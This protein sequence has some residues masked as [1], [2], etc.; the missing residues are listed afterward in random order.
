MT[1]LA[2]LHRDD[3]LVR[4]ILA[5]FA[6]VE[7]VTRG[8]SSA[9][10][11]LLGGRR[12]VVRAVAIAAVVTAALAVMVATPAW[13]LVRDVLPFWSQPVAS[14]PDQRAFAELNVG[15][16]SGMSPDVVAGETREVAH[17]NYG[18]TAR[19][20]WVAPAKNGGFCELWQPGGGG[21]NTGTTLQPL[22][23]T[24]VAFPP[25]LQSSEYAGLE[26]LSGFA[27]MPT[28]SDVVIRFSDGSSIRPQII[29]VS[30][31]INAGFFAYDIPSTQQTDA[32]HVTEIDAYDA[33]GNLVKRD[34]IE[35]LG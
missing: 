27:M 19:T 32:D 30:A 12:R 17:G 4:E 21:C 8:R 31:P 29:W 24:A 6:R 16:P 13:A 1:P 34:P 9:R 18:G 3:D 14:A 20:L 11:G 26:W 35:P 15:A 2:E 33:N 10:H 7:P 5:P 22:G 28:V 23:W 25:N